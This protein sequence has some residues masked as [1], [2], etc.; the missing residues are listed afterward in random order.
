M[1]GSLDVSTSA[2]VAQRTR[3]AAHAANAAGAHTLTNEKGEYDPFRR[4]V[5]IFAQGDGRGGAGVHVK[6]ILQEPAFKPV[7]EPN[8]PFADKK[9]N[10]YKPDID[11][12]V[13]QIN[14]MEASRAYEAN[15]TAAQ[16]TKSMLQ[17]AL[18]LL[19]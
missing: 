16:A 8:S 1:F 2:L 5:A 9:G 3:M 7:Y 10:V 6:E 18:R 19:A 17:S 15:I 4:R 13:E 12:A 14:M 11:P